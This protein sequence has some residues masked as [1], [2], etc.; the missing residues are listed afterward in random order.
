[1]YDVSRLVHH[2]LIY[3]YYYITIYIIIVIIILKSI[4]WSSNIVYITAKLP[5]QLFY[6]L[7]YFCFRLITCIHCVAMKLCKNSNNGNFMKMCLNIP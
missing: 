5:I 6:W 1:M 2:L 3:T 4:E 7:I